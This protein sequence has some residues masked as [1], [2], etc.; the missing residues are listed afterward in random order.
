MK[1]QWMVLPML[2]LVSAHADSQTLA[3]PV[4]TADPNVPGPDFPDA[5]ASLFDRITTDADGRQRIPFPFERLIERIE[6]RAGCDRARP[7]TRSVLIPLGRSLQRLAA[8]PD[9]Y[10]HPR[11]VT[12]V[13]GEGA[14]LMLRDR[15]YLGFQDRAGVVEVISYNEILGRFEFQVVSDYADGSMPKVTYA[16]RTVCIACHQNHGPIFS[17][18]LWLET[19]A[20]PHIAQRLQALQ[21]SFSGIPARVATDVSQAIDDATDRSTQLGLT[22]RLWR[23]GC[24]A[25]SEGNS[26]RRAAV[27]AALQL[28]LTGGR[29]Y[30]AHSDGFRQRVVRTLAGRAADRWHDGLAVPDA[31]I[32]NRDPLDTPMGVSGAQ[33]ADIDARLDPLVPRAPREILLPDAATL[34]GRLVS[35]L[36]AAWTDRRRDALDAALT[37]AGRHARTYTLTVPCRIDARGTEMQFECASARQSTGFRGSLGATSGVLEEFALGADEPMRYLHIEVA[38]RAVS[39]AVTVHVRDGQRSARLPDGNA[40]ETLALMPAGADAVITVREDFTS[41]ANAIAALDVEHGAEL[42]VLIEAVTARLTETAAPVRDVRRPVAPADVYDAIAADDRA[43]TRMFEAQCGRCHHTTSRTPPN[44]LAGNAARVESAL[45]SCRQRIFVRL[46]MRGLP[47]DRR[48]KSPMPPQRSAGSTSEADDRMLIELLATV[49]SQLTQQTGRAPV[50]EE[51]LR[52][53]YESLPPCLPAS[54][55]AG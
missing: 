24:G 48:A 14:G 55:P 22:Q 49:Q 27:G 33:Q 15:L 19:N 42:P 46:A 37:R 3:A 17:Q 6:S 20:N 7:C 10:A 11:I 47:F 28:A 9:F 54:L 12:A 8:S 40:L 43:A 35:G 18:Q 32:P 16:R 52:H 30:A 53:G 4:W 36:A 1:L 21:P 50:L 25:A 41:A 13:A 31:D 29:S 39:G 5:G 51:L 23:E 2:Q 45:Q 44:F 38:R 26:C 34:A